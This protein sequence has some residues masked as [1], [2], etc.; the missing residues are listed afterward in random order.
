MK[1]V[2]LLTTIF[3]TAAF[4]SESAVAQTEAQRIE[5]CAKMTQGATFVSSYPVQLPAARDG[6]RPPIFRQA[7]AMLKGNRYRF[8][9]CTGDDSSGEAVL[10]VLNAGRRLASSYN[11]ETGT[12]F[13]NVDIECQKT[14]AYVITVTFRDGREGT[15]VAI[16]SHVRT[17]N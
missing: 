15:A 3:F 12:S 10:E 11:P 5:L 9:I 1:K 4:F 6:E 16:L 14:D 17:L 7:V 2:I 13:I 8:T